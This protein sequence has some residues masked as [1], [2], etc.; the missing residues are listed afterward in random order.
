MGA[1]FAFFK[2]LR[3]LD[4]LD[5]FRPTLCN[6]C[7]QYFYMCGE[8]KLTYLLSI[9]ITIKLKEG[10]AKNTLHFLSE[11]LKLQKGFSQKLMTLKPVAV[12]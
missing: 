1:I 2:F 10:K 12:I 8:I 9:K 7:I 4:F 3:L 6:L 11:K 5:T